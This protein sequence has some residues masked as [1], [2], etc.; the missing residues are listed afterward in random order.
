MTRRPADKSEFLDGVI[1]FLC[2]FALGF[3]LLIGWSIIRGQQTPGPSL[4]LA[5]IVLAIWLLW[6][7]RGQSAQPEDDD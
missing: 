6:R 5:A 2:A 1:G 3:T 4:M 7:R